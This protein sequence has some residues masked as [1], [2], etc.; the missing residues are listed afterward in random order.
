MTMGRNCFTPFA[1]SDIRYLIDNNFV[2]YPHYFNF[3][4]GYQF[5]NATEEG[6][7]SHLHLREKPYGLYFIVKY[8]KVTIGMYFKR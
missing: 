2:L 8:R 1:A 3:T 6:F 7:G 5:P 4:T